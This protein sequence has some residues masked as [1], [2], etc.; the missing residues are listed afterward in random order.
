MADV[1]D[2]SP[3]ELAEYHKNNPARF[4]KPEYRAIT[5]IYLDP[6]KAAAELKPD[7]K[8][9]L[10]EYEYRKETLGVPERRALEQVLVQDEDTARKISQAAS[11]GRSLA[12][13]AKAKRCPTSEHWRNA[14]CRK[15]LPARPSRCRITALR[16]R[17]RRRSAG[18]SFG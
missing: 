18:T 13:A 17:S 11:E 12:D 5:M 3:A 9:I 8:R 14:T 10:E 15:N 1:P 6:D 2:P 7:E 16:R 4:T